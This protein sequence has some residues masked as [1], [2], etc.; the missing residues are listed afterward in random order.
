MKRRNVCSHGGKRPVGGNVIGESGKDGLLYGRIL[1]GIGGFYYVDEGGGGSLWECRLRG[2]FRREKQE[3]LP[4]DMVSF[5]VVDKGKRKGIVE[6]VEPRKNRLIR[7]TVANVDQALVVLAA[8]SPP[9]DLWLLDRLLLMIDAEDVEPLICWNKID[10]V[11]EGELEGYRK[12]YEATGVAQVATSAETL[13]GVDALSER[14]K[15]RTTVL[16]G[17]SG[18]GKSSLLNQIEPGIALKTGEVSDKLGRG[19]HATR[20]VEWI[21][22]SMGGWVAD[23]PGFS[24][25]VMPDIITSDKL[26]LYFPE[27]EPYLEGCRFR[28][29]LH[30]QEQDC[31][32][33]QGVRDG[34]IDGGRYRRYLAFLQELTDRETRY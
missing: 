29:C 31:G 5:A 28:S 15:G 25:I 22:L 27:F 13:V 12:P 2:R 32:I 34:G 9:P 23:T 16:A 30:D 14:L 19:R 8:D 10:L 17:P 11:S 33:S 24:Q 6:A 21:P 18:V 1:K 4:G 26:A 20:H 3:V 7:P